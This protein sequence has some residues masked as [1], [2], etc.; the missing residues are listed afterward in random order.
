MQL[1][2]RPLCSAFILYKLLKRKDLNTDISGIG[3]IFTNIS[4][5]GFYFSVTA[6]AHPSY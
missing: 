5:E 3:I 6:S 4:S 1:F 2:D